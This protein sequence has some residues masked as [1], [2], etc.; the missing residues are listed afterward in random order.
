[1]E[2]YKVVDKKMFYNIRY[3]G[4]L[5]VYYLNIVYFFE[6]FFLDFWFWC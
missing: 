1:M 3:I 6:K 4:Y 2:K 5:L